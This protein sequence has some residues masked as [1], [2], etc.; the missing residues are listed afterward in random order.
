MDD[1]DL[2][3]AK[4]QLAALMIEQRISEALDGIELTGDQADRLLN[5]ILPTSMRTGYFN[6]RAE[7]LAREKVGVRA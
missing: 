2:V 5:L 4:Q 6:W 7:Q 3:N 1:R